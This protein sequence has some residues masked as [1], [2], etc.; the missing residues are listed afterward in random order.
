M[1]LQSNISGTAVTSVLAAGENVNKIGL[2]IIVAQ[3]KA[4]LVSK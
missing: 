3:K 1:A 2:D 4:N